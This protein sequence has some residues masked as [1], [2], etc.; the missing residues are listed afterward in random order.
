MLSPGVEGVCHKG[1][2][3]RYG[4]LQARDLGQWLR[5]RYVQRLGFLPQGEQEVRVEGCRG[6]GVEGWKGASAAGQL[7][8]H[9]TCVGGSRRQGT[10]LELLAA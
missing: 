10:G 2:L 9:L 3:T 5:E 6:G 8:P 7:C 4:Q 1:Q